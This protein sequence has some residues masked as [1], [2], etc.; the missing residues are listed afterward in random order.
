[1]LCYLQ[2]MAAI[3]KFSDPTHQPQPSRSDKQTETEF[4]NECPVN[5]MI[6]MSR[7]FAEIAEKNPH[8]HRFSF[9]DGGDDDDVEDD[10][11]GNSGADDGLPDKRKQCSC[12]EFFFV[13][14][15]GCHVLSMLV[16]QCLEHC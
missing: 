5:L 15:I 13:L 8:L 7:I 9:A 4:R 14:M 12:G 1:M 2:V 6:S 3:L 16:K 10:V 11:D